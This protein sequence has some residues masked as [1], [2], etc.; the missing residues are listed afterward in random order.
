M[1]PT[2]P[3]GSDCASEVAQRRPHA[4]RGQRAVSRR[5]RVLIADAQPA[6]RLGTTAALEDGGLVVVSQVATAAEAVAGAIALRPEICV[7][8]MSI[9]GGGLEATRA[10]T[11]QVSSTVVLILTDVVI[12]D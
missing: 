9:S 6:A 2:T 5:P 4:D 12:E 10:I 11:T 8:D 7:V 3:R 1:Q